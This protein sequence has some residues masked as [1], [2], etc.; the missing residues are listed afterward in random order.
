MPALADRI[1]PIARKL[2]AWPLYILLALPIPYYFY[3]AATGGM[4]PEPINALERKI[5]EL[6]IQVVILGLAI[7]PLCKHARLNLIK[8]RRSI[9]IMAFVYVL[10]HFGFWVVLD[11]NL[12]WEQM[13]SDVWKRPYITIGMG[14]FFWMIPLVVTSNDFSIR[15]MGAASWRKLHKLVYP[16][17]VLG[18]V[19]FILVQKVWELEPILYLIVVL[20]LLTFRYKRPRKT[21]GMAAKHD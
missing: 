10:V 9:G 2:P 6:A 21:G 19:H 18:A 8:F 12:R 13:W 20:G 4:G 11:M 3:L 16:I 17:A 1:N 15:K 14:A 7:S 5:G